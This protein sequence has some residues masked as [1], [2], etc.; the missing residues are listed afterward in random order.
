MESPPS[1]QLR[2]GKS[3]DDQENMKWSCLQCTYLNWNREKD[4]IQCHIKKDELPITTDG[5]A[6][7]LKTL[8]VRGVSDLDLSAMARKSKT[9]SPKASSSNLSSSKNDLSE[10]AKLCYSESNKKSDL[11]WQC[12]VSDF[13]IC[14][15]ISIFFFFFF[16]S[17]KFCFATI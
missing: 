17:K 9:N 2:I 6:D 12:L 14:S 16:Y 7:D 15:H 8:S 1:P 13:E 11:K 4:C 5:L 10:G 3:P